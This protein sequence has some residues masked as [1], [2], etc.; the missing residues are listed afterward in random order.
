VGE[1]LQDLV[2]FAA[3][4][5]G[6]AVVVDA[7]GVCVFRGSSGTEKTADGKVIDRT[8]EGISGGIPGGMLLKPG[9]SYFRLRIDLELSARTKYW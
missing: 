2:V 4:W 6:P 5:A 3:A 8:G 1:G 9:V 7:V